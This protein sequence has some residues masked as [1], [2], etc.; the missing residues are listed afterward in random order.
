MSVEI[1][2]EFIDRES[3]QHI[4]LLQD[5]H[6]RKKQVQASILDGPDPKEFLAKEVEE[7]AA[8]EQK[9]ADYLGKHGKSP[10]GNP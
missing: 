10:A 9:I 5:S 2:R 8:Q 6:G 7:F 1:I 3:A 4:W